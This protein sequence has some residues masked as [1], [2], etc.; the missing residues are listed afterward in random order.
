MARRSRL[1]PRLNL[2]PA[3]VV[4]KELISGA[5]IRFTYRVPAARVSLGSRSLKNI[6]ADDM[7][8]GAQ[9]GIW[10]RLVPDG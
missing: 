2:V 3:P 8:L 9:D 4:S 7:E 6:F 10:P 5:P 1:W